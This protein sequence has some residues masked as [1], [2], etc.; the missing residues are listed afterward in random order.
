METD[1][2]SEKRTNFM[3]D[4]EYHQRFFFG[5]KKKKNRLQIGFVVKK[6]ERKK[7]DKE[8]NWISKR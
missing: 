8:K 4:G 2:I 6:R 5:E 7:W 1:I 3:R